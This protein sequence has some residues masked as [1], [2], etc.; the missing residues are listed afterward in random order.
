MEDTNF[1]DICEPKSEQSEFKSRNIPNEENDPLKDIEKSERNKRKRIRSKQS[2]SGSSR[3]AK[4]AMRSRSICFICPQ[5][6]KDFPTDSLL[7]L[8]EFMI[9]E[10]KEPFS[11]DNGNC[12]WRSI[13][14]E[15]LSIHMKEIHKKFKCDKCS[16]AIYFKR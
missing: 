9:H 14:I 3:R 4:K 10:G 15:D 1:V 12:K 16:E 13:S 2:R 7:K 6:D 8:H 5:C 11:C